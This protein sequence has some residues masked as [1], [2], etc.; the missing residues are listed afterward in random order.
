MSF[1]IGLCAVL[2]LVAAGVTYPLFRRRA[3]VSL[4][5][6][7]I[8]FAGSLAWFLTPVCVPIPKED[9]ANFRPPI[10][11]RT[12]TGM[13][14]QRYFQQRGGNWYHCKARIARALFF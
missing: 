13:A 4:T 7:I 1:V 8:V 6:G 2:G 3:W 11:T 5:A 12:E 9:L 14:G 10:E